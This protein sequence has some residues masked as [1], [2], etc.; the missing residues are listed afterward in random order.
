[1]HNIAICIENI[2]VGYPVPPYF[3][4]AFAV[5]CLDITLMGKK[6][7]AERKISFCHVNWW[8]N[9]DH[10]GFD[11][12]FVTGFANWR[13]NTIPW[14]D[15]DADEKHVM[16]TSVPHFDI[17]SSL[18]IHEHDLHGHVVLGNVGQIGRRG[19]EVPQTVKM[20][21]SDKHDLLFVLQGYH[22]T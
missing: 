19:N 5:F 12:L 16:M 3:Q 15:V 14:H 22:M 9:A 13:S 10:L 4:F 20:R 2:F 6:W 18:F 21:C 8:K 11:H 17:C 7:S 1:M